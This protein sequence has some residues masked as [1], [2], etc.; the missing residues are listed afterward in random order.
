MIAS[1]GMYINFLLNSKKI[2]EYEKNRYKFKYKKTNLVFPVHK[3][4]SYDQIYIRKM[5]TIDE[6][7]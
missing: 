6:E 3:F 2:L 5:S 4:Y 1:Y 7:F